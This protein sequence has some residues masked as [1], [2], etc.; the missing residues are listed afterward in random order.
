MRDWLW[1]G[2]G[3]VLDWKYCPWLK[4]G[5]PQSNRTHP[6]PGCRVSQDRLRWTQISWSQEDIQSNMQGTQNSLTSPSDASVLLASPCSEL[7]RRTESCP[8]LVRSGV[9]VHASRLLVGS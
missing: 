6:R 5:V 9:T 3:L 1:T 2:S 7:Y 4:A 8:P